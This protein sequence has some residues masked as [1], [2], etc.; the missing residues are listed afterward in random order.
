MASARA[1]S[2][3]TATD[4]RAGHTQRAAG[5]IGPVP[6]PDDA[7]AQRTER[8]RREAYFIAARRGFEP[9]HEI[10]DWLAAERCVDDATRPIPRK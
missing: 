10:E 1:A 7:A 6:H 2:V 9:G 5:V 3:R 4:P 8:V